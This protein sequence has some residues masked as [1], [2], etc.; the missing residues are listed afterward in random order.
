[1]MSGLFK[2][3]HSAMCAPASLELSFPCGP[4]CAWPAIIGVMLKAMHLASACAMAVCQ[5]SG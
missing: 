4:I 3:A 2:I 1:M 5:L